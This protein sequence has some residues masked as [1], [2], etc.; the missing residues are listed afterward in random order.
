MAD[1]AEGSKNPRVE[2]DSNEI[3]GAYN[4]TV[5]L[6]SLSSIGYKTLELLKN[7]DLNVVV[8]DPYVTEKE[9]SD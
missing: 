4:R 9:A 1:G 6:I 7:Y 5:G 2:F 3:L 8:Y